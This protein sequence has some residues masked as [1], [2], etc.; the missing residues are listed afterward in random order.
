M[1]DLRQVVVLLF[2]TPFLKAQ[3]D[4]RYAKIFGGPGFWV[5]TWLRL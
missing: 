1:L 2:G 3:N 4:Y 5:R